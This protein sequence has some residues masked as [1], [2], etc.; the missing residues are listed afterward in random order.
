MAFSRRSGSDEVRRGLFG[1]INDGFDYQ[2]VNGLTSKPPITQNPTRQTSEPYIYVFSVRERE[3]DQQKRS[4]PKEYYLYV[5]ICTRYNSYGGGQRQVNRMMDEVVRAIRNNGYPDLSSVGYSIYNLTIGEIEEFSFRERGAN[6]YKARIPVLIRA[7]FVDLPQDINPVQAINYTYSGFTFA[8]TNNNIERYDSGAIT[9]ATSYPSSNNGWDFLD[10]NYS[11]PQNVAGTFTGGNY[12]IPSGGEPLAL[13]SS[14]RYEFAADNTTTTTLTATNSWNV[15]DSIRYGAIDPVVNGVIPT[16]TD[17]TAAT[18][19][20]R[21]LSNWNIE[22]GTVS[23]HN[24]TITVTG[25][26]NQ[27]VYI[28]VDSNVTLTQIINNGVNTISDFTTQTVGDYKIYINEQ[29]IVF[30][31]YT[32]DFILIA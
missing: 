18:Y 31:D 1:R 4:T 15:I 22:Y 27:Y 5:E 8:P 19:G 14:L 32:A 13:F 30:N 10:A 17:D 11:L 6:Y 16:F 3:V 28:V 2:R 29:P 25:T 21:D 24:E 23:P 20:L 12:N 26:T 7:E 9:P